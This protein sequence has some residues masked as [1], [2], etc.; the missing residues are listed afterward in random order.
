MYDNENPDHWKRDKNDE[1][2]IE[3]KLPNGYNLYSAKGGYT[4]NLNLV[5]KIRKLSV[6]VML[7]DQDE[8]EG[9]DFQ[10]DLG[11]HHEQ[12]FHN[13]TEINERGSVIVFPSFLMHQVTPVT[14]GVRKSLVIWTVGPKYK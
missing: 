14:K 1:P 11:P 13:V 8:F 4:D 6:T 10:L 3:F 7:S 5:D 12:R 9:G 2:I